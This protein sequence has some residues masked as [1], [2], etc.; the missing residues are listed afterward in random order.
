MIKE[1]FKMFTN[2]THLSHQSLAERYRAKIVARKMGETVAVYLVGMAA[3]QGFLSAI[4]SKH[5][6]NA[7][8]MNYLGGQND[9]SKSDWLKF[10]TGNFTT[11]LSGGIVST[12]DFT[13]KMVNAFI[14][15]SYKKHGK[16]ITE[17]D[18]YLKEGAK[19]A[20]GKLSPF[21][22]H[23]ID[24]LMKRTYFGDVVPW[25]SDDPG[26]YN[27]QL[28]WGKYL[29]NQESPIFIAEGLKDMAQSMKDQ[30]ISEAQAREWF[31]SSL[32][33]VITGGTG[34]KVGRMREGSD[35]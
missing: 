9:P 10:K 31:E 35:Y 12:V 28:G 22:S 6:V 7:P 30:G 4:G 18:I 17:E 27:E 24:V 8:L 11:D 21:A 23:A 14:T 25:S 5:K 3:N 16:M 1:P 33:A 2:F 29:A 34:V 15:G 20:R 13:G 32:I 19:Y 26:K